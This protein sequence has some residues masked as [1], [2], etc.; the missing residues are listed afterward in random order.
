VA[1]NSINAAEKQCI[2]SLDCIGGSWIADPVVSLQQPFDMKRQRLHRPCNH[3]IDR[4][5]RHRAGGEVRKRRCVPDV[6]VSFYNPS[7]VHSLL[8]SRQRVGLP[9][10]GLLAYIVIC[11]IEKPD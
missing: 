1:A 10:A 7:P 6:T 9:S 8:K 5:R 3:M 11:F 4:R 2:A